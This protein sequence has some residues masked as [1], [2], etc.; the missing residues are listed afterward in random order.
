MP[1]VPNNR[2]YI[3]VRASELWKL[4]WIFFSLLYISLC[5]MIFKRYNQ[6]LWGPN[7]AVRSGGGGGLS[8]RFFFFFFFF[9]FNR[10]ANSYLIA[11]NRRGKWALAPLT[12]ILRHRHEE[13][14]ITIMH[15]RY[16]VLHWGIHATWGFF[17]G[18]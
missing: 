2:E 9:F 8:N 18:V 5:T 7:W 16:K 11:K 17:E 10:S 13:L 1:T 6:N 15:L 3:C 4:L 14:C 12:A